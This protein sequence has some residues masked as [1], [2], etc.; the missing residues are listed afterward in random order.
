MLG[1]TIIFIY[2]DVCLEEKKG[3]FKPQFETCSHFYVFTI[4]SNVF[5]F[6]YFFFW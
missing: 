3:H 4:F 6:F 1:T 2:V 5:F